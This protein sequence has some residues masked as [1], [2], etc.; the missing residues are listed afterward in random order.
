MEGL[1]PIPPFAAE[2][3]LGFV[4]RVFTF[5][6]VFVTLTLAFN[7]CSPDDGFLC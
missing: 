2:P 1:L 4:P 5:F 3:F 7:I 6:L